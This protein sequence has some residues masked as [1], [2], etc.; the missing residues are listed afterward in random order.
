MLKFRT[1]QRIL[2]ARVL[3]HQRE[4]AQSQIVLKKVTLAVKVQMR[5]IVQAVRILLSFHGGGTSNHKEKNDVDQ[6]KKEIKALNKTD[7]KKIKKY[8]DELVK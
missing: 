6:I 3:V 2:L 8:V 1:H 7:Q 4:V 5:K